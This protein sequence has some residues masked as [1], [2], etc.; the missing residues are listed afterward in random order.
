[1]PGHARV[2]CDSLSPVSSPDPWVIESRLSGGMQGGAWRVRGPAGIAGAEVDRRR[3][4][5]CVRRRGARTIMRVSNAA[6]ARPRHRQ[7]RT[8]VVRAGAR[9]GRADGRP[10]C[11]RRRAHRAPRL[12]AADHHAADDAAGRCWAASTSSCTAISPYR[13]SCCETAPSPVSSTSTERRGAVQRWICSARPRRRR[14]AIRPSSDR[15]PAWL[16][17]AATTTH[18]SRPLP[19]SSPARSP[20]GTGTRCRPSSLASKRRS[21]AAH[22]FEV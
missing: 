18:S 21:R 15:D 13:T 19:T 12:V 2:G 14:L 5:R 11:G 4:R 22:S 9:R 7:G 8:I 20:T 17:P 1:M 3:G 16:P 6:L 10:R